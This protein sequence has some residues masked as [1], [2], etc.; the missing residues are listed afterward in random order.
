MK[1]IGWLTFMIFV[2][3]I[4]VSTGGSIDPIPLPKQSEK[5]MP[6]KSLPES[7]GIITKIEGNR[8][9]L[10]PENDRTKMIM[11]EV[12]ETKEFMV[13]DRVKAQEGRLIHV[14]TIPTKPGGIKAGDPIPLPKTME[15]GNPPVPPNILRKKGPDQ[16]SVKEQ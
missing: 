9:T 7:Q 13:G 14:G 11:I 12:R 1:T 5:G 16:T 6:T 3:I 15:G 8:V 10:I 2:L 4:S